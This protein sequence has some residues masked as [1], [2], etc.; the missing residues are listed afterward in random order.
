MSQLIH[1]EERWPQIS[2]RRR[3]RDAF[4]ER[5]APARLAARTACSGWAGHKADDLVTVIFSSGSTGEPKGVMLTHGN[6]AA[7]VEAFKDYIDFD[8]E[9]PRARHPAVLPQLRLHG[10]AVGGAAGRGA[11]VYHPD[12]RAAKE[13]GELCRTHGCTL[14][15]ATATF[16]RLYLRRCEPDDFKTHAAA[17]LRGREAAA[18]ADRGVPGE[19]RRPAAGRLRLHRTVARS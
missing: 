4:L 18:G 19:V 2:R 12:P 15:A 1:V 5:A 13:V 17:G 14:M 8:A 3:R 9:G 10:D 11:A 6:V 16:L 7:N